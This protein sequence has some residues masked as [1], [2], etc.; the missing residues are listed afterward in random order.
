MGAGNV[1]LTDAYGAAIQRL[2]TSRCLFTMGHAAVWVLLY[3]L[4]DP[5]M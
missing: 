1:L 4:I 2:R 3:P 5:E